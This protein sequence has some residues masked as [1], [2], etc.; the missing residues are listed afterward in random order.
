[1]ENST[2]TESTKEIDKAFNF[3][4]SMYPNS[5]FRIRKRSIKYKA[6]C[7]KCNSDDC[8]VYPSITELKTPKK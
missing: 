4:L 5:D 2:S 3:D 6:Y 1:M 7:N 8:F